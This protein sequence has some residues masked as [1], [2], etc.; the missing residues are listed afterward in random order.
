VSLLQPT[1]GDGVITNEN[2]V[3]HF[4]TTGDVSGVACA[5]EGSF[6]SPTQAS[7]TYTCPGDR[8]WGTWSVTKSAS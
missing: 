6:T 7:G 4:I 8:G 3:D 5:W 2:G 1:G